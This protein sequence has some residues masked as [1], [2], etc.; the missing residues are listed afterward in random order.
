LRVLFLLADLVFSLLWPTEE[1][2]VFPNLLS[3]FY[4]KL[5]IGYSIEEG[6]SEVSKENLELFINHVSDNEARQEKIGEEI[7]GEALIALGAE[8][9]WN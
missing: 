5:N 1:C 7:G 8:S 3:R 6:G 9:E 2:L 4:D